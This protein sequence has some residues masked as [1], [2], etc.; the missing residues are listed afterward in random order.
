MS[1][2]SEFAVEILHQYANERHCT[3][4]STQDLSQLEEWLIIRLAPTKED[5][6]VIGWPKVQELFEKEGFREN[7]HLI[8]EGQL[9]DMYGDSA[10]FV[11]K[12][13]L[14]A[15]PKEIPDPFSCIPFDIAQNIKDLNDITIEAHNLARAHEFVLMLE[16]KKSLSE[17]ELAILNSANPIEAAKKHL[18][19]KE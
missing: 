12:S 1:K 7:S 2:L 9:Y 15:I 18:K 8:V 17:E 3:V 13:W 19:N 5:F 10:Y 4:R 16:Q 14:N 6:I 11:K